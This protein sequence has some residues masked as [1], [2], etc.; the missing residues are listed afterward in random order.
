MRFRLPYTFL[1]LFLLV[2]I[3]PSS[4]FA[5]SSTIIPTPVCVSGFWDIA[6]GTIG[7]FFDRL[8]GQSIPENLQKINQS[9]VPYDTIKGSGNSACEEQVADDVSKTA[10]SYSVSRALK[11]NDNKG[12]ETVDINPLESLWQTFSGIFGKGTYEADNFLRQ[13]LP[14]A[15]ANQA[16]TQRIP[17]NE[18]NDMAQGDD[19][20]VLGIFGEKTEA[21]AVVLPALQCANLPYGVGDCTRTG[22][23]NPSGAPTVSPPIISPSP[24]G[25]TPGGGGGGGTVGTCPLGEGDYCSIENLKKPEFFKSEEPAR[26]AS[27]ICQ[28]ES[29]SNPFVINKGCLER[30]S[31]DY[32]VGLFQI[33]MLAQCEGAFDYSCDRNTKTY[34]CTI[35]DQAKLDKCVKDYSDSTTNIKKAYDMSG[36]GTHWSGDWSTAQGC[37]IP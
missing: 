2:F 20:R 4:V 24:G 12:P 31:C 17:A 37:N 3:L 9:Q 25:G 30:K 18:S 5:Q 21:M 33:N 26:L 14:A 35:I 29:H 32:S 1:C 22:N 13:A 11:V 19:P 34:A 15:A 16:L 23:P 6:Q 36:G 8:L 28:A 7:D 27:Q 10:K